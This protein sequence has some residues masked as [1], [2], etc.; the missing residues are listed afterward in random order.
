MKFYKHT[1]TLLIPF[2]LCQVCLAQLERIDSLKNELPVLKD[3]AKID[4]L[5]ALSEAHVY[6]QTDSA[7][8]FAQK[9]LEE[10]E[11]INYQNGIAAAWLNLAWATGLAGGK[12]TTMENYCRNAI[13]ILEKTG[14]K[15]QLA[16]SWFS[17]ACAL[18]SQCKFS[19]SLVAFDSAGRM[20]SRMGDEM[21]LARMYN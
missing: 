12:L 21:G 11:K 4:C 8:M 13:L 3:S 6:H 2:I 15:K 20:F 7:K 14:E 17:L 10:A 5:N 16:D 1:I 19:S 9:A 18:S